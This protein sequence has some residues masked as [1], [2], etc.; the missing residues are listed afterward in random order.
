MDAST[1]KPNASVGVGGL[2]DAS[3]NLLQNL[4]SNGFFTQQAQQQAQPDQLQLNQMLFQ[5][6]NMQSQQVASNANCALSQWMAS[7]QQALVNNNAQQQQ[8]PSL[9]FSAL[10]PPA[11][12]QQQQ[13]TQLPP[14]EPADPIPL[15]N[16]SWNNNN[17]TAE[18]L[19]MLLPSQDQHQQPQSLHTQEPDLAPLPVTGAAAAAVSDGELDSSASVT[20]GN[21]ATKAARFR[22]DQAEQWS[23]RYDELLDFLK[24]HGH[25]RVPRNHK[26]YNGLASWV[27][28]QRYQYKL[29]KEGKPSFLT[30][31]RVAVLDRLGFVWDSHGSVW[32]TRFQELQEF[33]RQF[34]HSNVP[35]NYGNAKLASWIKAQ[36]REMRAF[37][38]GKTIS[39]EMFQRFLKLEKYGFCWQLR[40]S[41]RK[42]QS[43]QAKAKA[44][45]TQHDDQPA[46]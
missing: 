34:G 1:F 19:S 46:L 10:L 4:L 24:K 2:D 38:E 45:A 8:D 44:A 43:K 7:Q 36:R 31:E 30:D 3:A 41:G 22:R 11:F 18:L 35:Y 13:Q 28:R 20:T 14:Q 37:K 21:T 16:L 12:Q 5:N 17:N 26:E 39:P 15:P 29:R 33:H 40:N 27:K 42:S 6:G 32:E 25:C 9:A 23:E